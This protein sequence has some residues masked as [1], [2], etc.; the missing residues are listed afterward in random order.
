MKLQLQ[1][2]Y[3]PHNPKSQPHGANQKPEHP[4]DTTAM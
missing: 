4:H 1:E 3:Q 2:A